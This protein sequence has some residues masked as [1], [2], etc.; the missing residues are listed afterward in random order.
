MSVEVSVVVP[1]YRRPDLL[2]NCLEA[3]LAQDFEPRAYE[4]VVVDNAGSDETRRLV[5][6]IAENNGRAGAGSTA[7]AYPAV[8]YLEETKRPGPAAA[9]NRGWK[10]A[11]GE[12]IAFTDDDC[13]PDGK[14]LKEGLRQLREGSDA[15][16]GRVVVPI[17]GIPTDY[18]K[19]IARLETADFVTANCFIRCSAIQ[20]AG[21]FDERFTTAWR[22]DSDLQFHILSLSLKMGRAPEAKVVHPVRP[23]SWDISLKEQRKSMFNALLFKKYPALYR[24]R[25]QAS[26]PWRYYAIT[27]AVIGLLLATVEGQWGIAASL[28]LCWTILTAGFVV[29]RLRGTRHTPDHIA[30]MIVTSMIIPPL[31]IFWRLYGALKY[32]TWFL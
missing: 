5:E 8:Y 25:I 20:A 6:S 30:E 7:S 28:G 3:L 21:G 9:R 19:N 10:F 24:E 15:V 13:I 26:P 4:I 32:R 17:R 16:I 27:G 22:E 31:S 29:K 1:T 18:E 14:W 23:A 11:H 12:I 2:R